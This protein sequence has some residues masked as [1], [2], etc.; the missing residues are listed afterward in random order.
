MLYYIIYRSQMHLCLYKRMH[1]H[2]HI[3]I[4]DESNDVVNKKKSEKSSEIS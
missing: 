2:M 4:K 1:P 3:F